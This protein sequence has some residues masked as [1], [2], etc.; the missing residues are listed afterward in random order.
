[1]Q[2]AGEGAPFQVGYGLSY[3]NVPGYVTQ[4]VTIWYQVFTSFSYMQ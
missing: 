1:M 2:V 4:R 3:S